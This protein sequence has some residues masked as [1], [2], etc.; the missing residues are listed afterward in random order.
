MSQLLPASILKRRTDVRFRVIDD[1]GVVVRQTAGEI[2]VLNEVATRILALADGAASI[3]GW[4]DALLAEYEVE[5][6]ALAAD[7]VAFAA[8]LIDQ[9]LLE[10]VAAGG[11]A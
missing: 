7:V 10:P 3:D 6:P 11:G 4:I 8:Q 1:E 2:M 9:G 5:R